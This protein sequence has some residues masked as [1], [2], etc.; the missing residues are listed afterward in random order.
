MKTMEY[1]VAAHATAQL[2]PNLNRLAK[3]GWRVVYVHY[4]PL[5]KPQWHV[6][7]ERERGR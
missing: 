1:E 5:G 4:D 3:E 2:K 6:L 7:L